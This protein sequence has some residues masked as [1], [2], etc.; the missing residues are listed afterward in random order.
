MDPRKGVHSCVRPV[1]NKVETGSGGVA[2]P[3][4]PDKAES[5]YPEDMH[6]SVEKIR[7]AAQTPRTRTALFALAVAS[8]VVIGLLFARAS[9]AQSLTTG[10]SST[11]A[12]LIAYTAFT[13]AG[14][15]GMMLLKA[16]EVLIWVATYNGFVT[17]TPVVTGWVIMRD[18]TNMFFILALLL[19]AFGT[20]LGVDKYSY[21]NKQ[22]SRLLIMAIVVNFSRTIAGLLIDF[23]QVVMLTFVN[24]F[25]A[26]AGGNFM[27]AFH[28]NEL[29]TSG[30]STL[31]ALQGD[32]PPADA[33]STTVSMILALA[34][35]VVSLMVVIIMTVVLLWRV[36]M[37]WLLVIMSPLAFFLSGVPG[38][39]GNGYYEK[40][41][42]EFKGQLVV[43][44]FLAF[45]LWLSLVSVAAAGTGS[46]LTGHDMASNA[47]S[48][49]GMSAAFEGKA[50]GS[51]AIAIALMLGGVKMAS[52][53]SEAV[54]AGK[55][56]AKSLGNLGQS[57][58]KGAVK[59]VDKRSGFQAYRKM[60]SARSDAEREAKYKN[61]G[62]AIDAGVAGMAGSAKGGIGSVL[63]LGGRTQSIGQQMNRL[64]DEERDLRQRGDIKGADKLAD[65][66]KSLQQKFDTMSPAQ[67]TLNSLK[68]MTLG[69]VGGAVQKSADAERKVVNDRKQEVMKRER[70]TVAKKGAKEVERLGSGSVASASPEQFAAAILEA[71]KAG[72]PAMYDG[73]TEARQ[74][75]V[76]GNV[77]TASLA[78]F[79]EN[80]KKHFFTK[81]KFDDD[82]E[83]NA[84]KKQDFV[85]SKF[86]ITED[87]S[88]ALVGDAAL[89][90]ARSPKREQHEEAIMKNP[91]M[92]EQYQAALM[93]QVKDIE[94]GTSPM[95]AGSKEHDAYSKALVSTAKVPDASASDTEKATPEYKKQ[96]ADYEQTLAAAYGIK[97]GAFT[98]ADA[99]KNT[100]RLID[101]ISKKGG[102]KMLVQLQPGQM[103][104][105]AGEATSLGKAVA[106]A[107]ES[108]PNILGSAA[109]KAEDSTD[110]QQAVTVRAAVQ[111]AAQEG[112]PGLKKQVK[113]GR[114]YERYQEPY[115][116]NVAAQAASSSAATA[117][118]SKTEQ[119]HTDSA[120]EEVRAKAD[121][122]RKKRTAE[123]E[124]QAK[125]D[126]KFINE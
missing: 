105:G 22:L 83:K 97:D 74:R 65:R 70:E 25:S 109:R 31:S 77:D 62:A 24:G 45:F 58:L 20:I 26:S 72:A 15:F 51:F 63:T 66:R 37:L 76:D 59:Q 18:V 86:A 34:L 95:A 84:K 120:R 23:S 75:L 49:P 33:W 6:P 9:H 41:W 50:I 113:E 101:A 19:I 112:G 5:C 80:T 119:E 82:P 73:V 91:A 71:M 89:M 126:S 47:E 56:F 99:E 21:R 100:Q 3:T 125:K 14:F 30:P 93:Q 46:M 32:V 116:A 81:A 121:E 13:I 38:G 85:N 43:G 92:R 64:G 110:K 4:V 8:A 11:V 124:E 61:R 7:T 104:D 118:A 117:A 29:Y 16:V 90:I 67:R 44:P 27:T 96:Q 108:N 35:T 106:K 103:I 12:L 40:W 122:R 111:V 79:D 10:L 36:I 57:A 88:P 39:A 69:A 54:G 94:A 114:A 115:R 28:I 68:G 42:T 87:T 2:N 55:G 48:I 102:D 107:L 1:S 52:S 17:A 123:A 78:E 60:S 53:M 98:G